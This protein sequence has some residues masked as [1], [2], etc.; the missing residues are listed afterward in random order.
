MHVWLGDVGPEIL[1]K[2]AFG[3]LADPRQGRAPRQF[4]LCDKIPEPAIDKLQNANCA[5]ASTP[6][7]RRASTNALIKPGVVKKCRPHR[8]KDRRS[9]ITIGK[10]PIRGGDNVCRENKRAA[11]PFAAFAFSIRQCVGE[12]PEKG[13]RFVPAARAMKSERRQHAADT[14]LRISRTRPRSAKLSGQFAPRRSF[15]EQSI[16]GRR[17]CLDPFS[18]RQRRVCWTR[19][20]LANID[21]PQA[22]ADERGRVSKH[23]RLLAHQAF[24]IEIAAIAGRRRPRGSRPPPG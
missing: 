24:E 21:K 10:Q 2:M 17:P 23:P 18:R 14:R 1:R 11:R 16:L 5:G 12:V 4:I 3:D 19:L 9:Q 8:L 7:A 20:A 22:A 15:G 13:Q 6:P